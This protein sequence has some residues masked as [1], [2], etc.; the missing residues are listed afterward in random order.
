MPPPLPPMELQLARRGWYHPSFPMSFPFHHLL[1]RWDVVDVLRSLGEAKKRGKTKR[2]NG[3][4]VGPP[5]PPR[6]SVVF[7][8]LSQV[9]PPL[10]VLF[11]FPRV[12]TKEKDLVNAAALHFLRLPRPLLFFFFPHLKRALRFPK[13]L[14]AT[15]PPPPQG[16]RRAFLWWILLC[17][18]PL[19]SPNHALPWPLHSH[20]RL[21]REREKRSPPRPRGE[22]EG[23]GGTTTKTARYTKNR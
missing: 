8:P 7:F 2:S 3:A 21:P 19:H 23:K 22:G 9:S 16:V 10:H 14:A 1:W 12:V 6:L 4:P 15:P 20:P 17:A 13:P 18:L 5:L 11:F